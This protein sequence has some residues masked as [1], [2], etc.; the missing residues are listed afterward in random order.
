[1]AHVL[2]PHFATTADRICTMAVVPGGP[3][4]TSL[5]YADQEATMLEF[6]IDGG[7]CSVGIHGYDGI[8]GK[9]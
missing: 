2:K 1:M 9:P 5:N 4:K 3:D 7:K 6:A 8:N